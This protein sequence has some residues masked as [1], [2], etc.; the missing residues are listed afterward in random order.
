M[1]AHGKNAFLVALA[2]AFCASVGLAAATQS[3][4]AV[5]ITLAAGLAAWALARPF[6]VWWDLFLVAL[7]GSLVLAYGFANIGLSGSAPVPL[8]DVL[9]LVLFLWAATTKTFRWPTTTPFVLGTV[10]VG[11]ACARLFFDVP[12]WG[13][14]AFRDFT[15]AFEVVCLPIGYW[16]LRT[17]GLER[18]VNA[19]KW[20]FTF[21]LVY[22]AFEPVADRVA[23]LGPTVGLQRPVPLLGS[24]AGAET[25]AAAG[26]FFFAIVRPF[27][28]LSYVLAAGFLAELAVFQLRGLYLAVPAAIVLVFMLAG[29]GAG[30]A[31]GGLAATLA[32]SVIVLALLLPLAPQGR[33]GPVSPWFTVSQ[34]RT[35]QGRAGPGSGSYQDRVTWFHGVVREVKSKGLEGWTVGVGLGPD[36]VGEVQG[37]ASA[38]R[39][40]HDDYLEIF[41]RLGLPALIVFAWMLLSSVITVVKAARRSNEVE[42]QFLWWIFATCVVYLLIAA[43]QPTFAFVY[44]TIPVFSLLG[45]GLALAERTRQGP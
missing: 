27:G 12:V 8:A 45:A 9:L 15:V 2:A 29:K 10:F 7:G 16:A 3:R 31:R 19:L 1:T 40:P 37:T 30:R 11:I 21:G 14:D 18:W 44:G 32:T 25:A 36:L 41:A 33:L 42:A 22:F 23:A 24:Y 17:Y 5:G 13:K 4:A 39:K 20:I 26:M 6:A 35:L 34:L 43:T 38:L 28:R